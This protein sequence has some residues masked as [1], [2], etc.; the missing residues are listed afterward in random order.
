MEKIAYYKKLSTEATTPQKM[1]EGDA[2]FVIFAAED[3]SI[4][5]LHRAEVGTHLSLELPCS[6]YGQ[7]VER[8][9]MCR[10]LGT[11]IGG[12]VVDSD[13]HGEIKV[14]I[15]NLGKEVIHIKKGDGIAQLIIHNICPIELRVI[16]RLPPLYRYF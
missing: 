14:N 1:D 13:F 10:D 8:F 3:H 6:T 5:P 15:F 16:D 11:I 4:L 2:G 9:A 7:I 12:G